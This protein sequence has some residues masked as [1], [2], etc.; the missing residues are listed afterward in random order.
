MLA[1]ILLKSFYGNTLKEWLI[2]L[3][4]ILGAIVIGKFL[5]YIFSKVFKRLTKRTKT[6]LDDIIVDMIEEPIVFV[7]VLASIWYAIKRLDFPEI[8][9]TWIGN[10]YQVVIVL[11]IAWFL[12]RLFDSLV[13]QYLV[14][15]AEKSKTDLDDQLLPLVSKGIKVIVWVIAIIIAL[16]NAGY[17]V[18]A[19]LAGLGIGGLAFAMAAKDTVANIFGGFTIFTDKPFNIKDRIKIEGYDGI[20]KE[21]GLR[22]TRL[23]TLEGRIVTIPNSTFAENPVENVTREPSRKVIMNLGLT[24]DTT[25]KQMQKALKILKQIQVKNQDIQEKHFI[26]FN[27]FGDFSL[28]LKFIYYIKKGSDILKTQTDINLEILTR[29]NKEKL[30]FAFP[31]QTILTKKL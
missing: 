18:G 30:D 15:L 9:H 5:Y 31:T 4:I 12:T 3:L 2:S 22:S 6:K 16:N 29:F 26:A 20:V 21:I 8:V 24:Y 7:L 17:N 23:Q 19:L 27:G 28:N 10:I 11:T 25:P 1:Q 13:R 14:P